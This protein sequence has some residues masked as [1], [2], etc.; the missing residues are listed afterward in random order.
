MADELL[1][2]RPH[3]MV[4]QHQ[5]QELL[6]GHISDVVAYLSDPLRV[7]ERPEQR[8]RLDRPLRALR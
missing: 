2:R 3:L 8:Y 7:T 5:S 1:G 4:P 6:H